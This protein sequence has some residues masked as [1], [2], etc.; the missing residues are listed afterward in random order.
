MRFA[1][2]TALMLWYIERRHSS[3]AYYFARLAANNSVSLSASMFG[4]G[5]AMLDMNDIWIDSTTNAEGVNVGY[6]ERSEVE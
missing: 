4:D 1:N 3:S 2:L 6:M 5:L